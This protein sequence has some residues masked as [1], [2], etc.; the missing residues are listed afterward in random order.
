MKYKVAKIIILKNDS[1]IALIG[2]CYPEVCITKE[3]VYG[4][5]IEDPNPSYG[6][7]VYHSRFIPMREIKEIGFPDQKY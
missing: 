4:R 7:K 1:P 6:A 2:N 3:G 5:Q